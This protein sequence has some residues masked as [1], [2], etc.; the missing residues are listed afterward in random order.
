MSKHFSTE[1]DC[2]RL[3]K[4]VFSKDPMLDRTH[5]KG[6]DAYLKP[7]QMATEDFIEFETVHGLKQKFKVAACKK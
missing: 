7:E 3:T 4:A 1:P 6:M 5:T 2:S